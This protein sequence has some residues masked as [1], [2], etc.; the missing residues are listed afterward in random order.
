MNVVVLRGSL[1]SEPRAQTLPSGS[2][3]LRWEVTTAAE[4]GAKLSVPVVWFDPAVSVQR[5]G[6]G[7]DVVIAGQVRRSF[8]RAGGRTV[9]A[10]DVVAT[11]AALRR[12]LGAAKLVER[13]AQQL[14]DHMEEGP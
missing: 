9:S 7:D 4:D 2:L 6:A 3:L 1:S 5:I 8:F 13:S 14:L 11:R 10:T 12:H